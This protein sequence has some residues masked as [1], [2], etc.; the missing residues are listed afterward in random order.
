MENTTK[1]GRTVYAI[2]TVKQFKGKTYTGEI[3]YKAK[4]ITLALF[5]GISNRR[6]SFTEI[7]QTYY[8]EVVHAILHDMKHPLNTN[9]KFVDGFAKRLV[10]RQDWIAKQNKKGKKDAD[11]LVSQFVERL[12]EL[13]EKVPRSKSAKKVQARQH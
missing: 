11:A 8:H 1:I 9:E 12:R 10:G 13:R 6:L 2:K 3:D 7:K 4:T 5:G